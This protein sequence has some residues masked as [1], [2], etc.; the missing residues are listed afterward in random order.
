MQFV[1]DILMTSKQLVTFKLTFESRDLN[2]HSLL[3][4]LPE[5]RRARV[6]EIITNAT[7]ELREALEGDY[8]TWNSE[9]R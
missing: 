7:I 8:D 6:E 1:R 9:R 5:P 3:S 2:A 4:G